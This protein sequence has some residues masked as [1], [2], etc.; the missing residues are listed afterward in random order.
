MRSCL[1]IAAS[2]GRT[3]P[4]AP[5]PATTTVCSPKAAKTSA[6]QRFPAHGECF[7][8]S[9]ATR[10]CP[11]LRSFSE[12][13]YLI[14]NSAMAGWSRCVPTTRSSAGWIWVSRPRIRFEVAVACLA[15][16]SSKPHNIESSA[17]CSS[18]STTE[19]NVCGRDRASSAMM[20][21]S[22][23]SVLASF[24]TAD[25]HGNFLCWSGPH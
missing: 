12:D 13:G 5:V 23:A 19:R 1:S 20:A 21:A 4:A 18:A 10:V 14:S 9:V 16:S 7:D 15:K 8:S 11:A 22:L 17:A 24:V 3:M 2:W 6:A 25:L